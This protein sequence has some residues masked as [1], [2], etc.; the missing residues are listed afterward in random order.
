MEEVSLDP[1]IPLLNACPKEMRSAPQRHTCDP[2][3]LYHY[4]ESPINGI[5]EVPTTDTQIKKM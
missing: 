5:T 1:K 4:S 3:A 2:C